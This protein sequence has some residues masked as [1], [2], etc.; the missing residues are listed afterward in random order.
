MTIIYRSNSQRTKATIS[1]TKKITLSKL[2]LPSINKY[3]SQNSTKKNEIMDD[4]ILPMMNVH[5]PNHHT[6]FK[7]L[8]NTFNHR[9]IAY[10]LN[11]YNNRIN[12][13][14]K[15]RREKE[16]PVNTKSFQQVILNNSP[17][18]TNIH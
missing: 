8:V 9:V 15:S 2:L 17:F 7:H 14:P 3:G 18:K 1:P 4:T 6:H 11:L 10:Y 12:K 5:S 13:Y 16:R